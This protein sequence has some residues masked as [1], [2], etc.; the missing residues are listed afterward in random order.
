MGTICQDGKARVLLYVSKSL[1]ILRGCVSS[2]DHHSELLV[3]HISATPLVCGT[4]GPFQIV[5][6]YMTHHRGVFI[7]PKTTAAEWIVYQTLE[8]AWGDRKGV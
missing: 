5:F 2:S 8:R 3:L 4:A 1:S 7:V 6:P